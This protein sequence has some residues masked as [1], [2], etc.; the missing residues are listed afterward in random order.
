MMCNLGYGT[1]W[2]RI[3]RYKIDEKFVQFMSKQVHI[4]HIFVFLV[5]TSLSYKFLIKTV[6]VFF[7]GFKL[8]DFLRDNETLSEFLHHNAS[9]PHHALRKILEAEVNLEKVRSKQL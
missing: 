2:N 8:K 9:L 3:G 1:A 6:S 5:K 4:S 7:P